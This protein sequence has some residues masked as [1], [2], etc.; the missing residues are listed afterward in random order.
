MIKFSIIA[1]IAAFLSCAS[2]S[3]SS[4]L[5]NQNDDCR[6]SNHVMQVTQKYFAGMNAIY[7]ERLKIN[8]DVKG[9]IVVV[10]YVQASGLIT[11]QPLIES[12]SL[13]DTI[14]ENRLIEFIKTWNYGKCGC[15]NK[16]MQIVYPFDFN[17][18]SK[19]TKAVKLYEH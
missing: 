13:R 7:N 5:K 11:Q 14:L 3:R 19:N 17:S 9:R 1:F 16:T 6:S 8:P 2:G 18:R 12:S 10:F 15:R 4:A